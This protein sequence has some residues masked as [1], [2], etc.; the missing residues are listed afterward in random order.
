MVALN[1]PASTTPVSP[2]AN[3]YPNDYAAAFWVFVADASTVKHQN[4]TRCADCKFQ[5]GVGTG[6]MRLFVDASFAPVAFEFSATAGLHTAQ[7]AMGRLLGA[8]RSALRGA[9]ATK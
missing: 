4:D 2:S 6:A 5:T 9:A 8:A 1:A 7:F 3:P